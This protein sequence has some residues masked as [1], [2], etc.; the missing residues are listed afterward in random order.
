MSHRHHHPAHHTPT[1]HHRHTHHTPTHDT[2][3]PDHGS[4]SSESNKKG[5]TISKQLTFVIPLNDFPP[6]DYACGK[7]WIAFGDGHQAKGDV[8]DDYVI[9]IAHPY[10]TAHKHYAV[11]MT[12][13]MCK[14]HKPW[15]YRK[16]QY[17]D[18]FWIIPDNGTPANVGPQN[19]GPFFW[20]R[21]F[22]DPLVGNVPWYNNYSKAMR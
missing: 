4:G 14:I 12:V 13:Q 22:W 8:P 11:T 2:T 9:S 10:P 5:T 21:P 16:K 7:Y 18:Q 1:H 6:K 3:T 20:D 17:T 19:R 15:G